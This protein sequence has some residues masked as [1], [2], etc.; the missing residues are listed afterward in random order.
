MQGLLWSKDVRS[1]DFEKDKTY[2]VHQILSYGDI[3]DIR[4]LLGIYGRKEVA[5]VFQEFPKKLYQPAVF[6][7]VR[8]ILLNLK[9]TK[10][11][12]NEYVKTS[13]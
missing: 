7:F 4:W 10:F 5:R 13:P 9:G 11:G 8:D 1:L 3:K 2:I 6:Y 12:P